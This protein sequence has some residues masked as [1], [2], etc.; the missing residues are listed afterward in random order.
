VNGGVGEAAA[1]Y[2]HVQQVLA[3][4]LQPPL[5]H[6]WNWGEGVLQACEAIVFEH[7]VFGIGHA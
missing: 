6:A 1:S 2:V 7:G 4:R 3:I 5:D